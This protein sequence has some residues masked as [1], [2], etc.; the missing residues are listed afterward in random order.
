MRRFARLARED[1]QM[2][3]IDAV[4]RASLLCAQRLGEP[5][6]LGR[7]GTGVK[8]HAVIGTLGKPFDDQRNRRRE[9]ARRICRPEVDSCRTFAVFRDECDIWARAI[10]RARGQRPHAVLAQEQERG[11]PFRPWR[12]RIQ[13]GFARDPP[14]GIPV[15]LHNRE[16]DGLR[17]Q[18]PHAQLRKGQEV[19]DHRRIRGK[20]AQAFGDAGGVDLIQMVV[21]N[22]RRCNMPRPGANES[23]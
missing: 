4:D 3:R 17:R 14:N 7:R 12:R 20:N 16:N 21:L 1:M 11:E 22:G 2:R 13:V 6:A 9:N 5:P 19:V 23:E 15:C 10:E 18:R 8:R